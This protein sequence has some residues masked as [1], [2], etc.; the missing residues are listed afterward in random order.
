MCGGCRTCLHDQGY[1]CG[2]ESCC[3]PLEP[4]DY[5]VKIWLDETDDRLVVERGY[6]DA[7][8]EW[9]SMV[10]TRYRMPLDEEMRRDLLEAV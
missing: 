8:D 4:E 9:V 2:D 1:H 3:G 7:D 6:L 5:R 10:A